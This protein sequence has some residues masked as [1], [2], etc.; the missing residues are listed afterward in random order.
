[1]K[2][3][4]R[5]VVFLAFFFTPILLPTEDNIVQGFFIFALVVGAVTLLMWRLD[6]L[7]LPKKYR[8][9]KEEKE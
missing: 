3:I 9:G 4:L 6:M 2:N 7:D 5:G 1:M 8:Y